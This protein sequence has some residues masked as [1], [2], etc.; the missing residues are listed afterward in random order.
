M[1]KYIIVIN[2]TLIFNFYNNIYPNFTIF[3]QVIYELQNKCFNNSEKTYVI[4]IISI[5]SIIYLLYISIT[6]TN[7]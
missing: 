7:N 2:K 1:I 3:K 5:Y 6:N 4:S